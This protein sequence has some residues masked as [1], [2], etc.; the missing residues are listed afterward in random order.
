MAPTQ[1]N[2]SSRTAKKN[3]ASALASAP[4][5]SERRSLAPTSKS[6]DLV[7]RAEEAAAA[8]AKAVLG[9]K[10]AAAVAL[11]AAECAKAAASVALQAAES[12][13][14]AALFAAAAKKE[15][16]ISVYEERLDALDLSAS[17]LKAS[18]HEYISGISIAAFSGICVPCAALEEYERFIILKA[19]NCDWLDTKLSSSPIVDEIWKL[20]L[21]DSH[22]YLAMNRAL[23]PREEFEGEQKFL[24]RNSS[25]GDDFAA[26]AVRIA[27]TKRESEQCFELGKLDADRLTKCIWNFEE[28]EEE[29]EKKEEEE[30]EKETQSI[31]QVFVT[32]LVGNTMC[33]SIN[34]FKPMSTFV[35]EVAAKTGIPVDMIRLR[36]GGKTIHG[37]TTQT[38]RDLGIS[39]DSTLYSAL[40][41]RG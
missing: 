38:T 13:K 33:F 6:K 10:A 25:G 1:N 31:I 7:L 22:S 4:H 40:N 9:A 2:T 16:Q 34:V 26:R 15:H 20:H 30:E 3:Q 11:Q 41:F 32:G 5:C 8:D 21:I 36:Y 24:H 14:T 29:E 28:K 18:V 39:K 17:P 19:I 12:A 37:N 27:S 23:F 35:A